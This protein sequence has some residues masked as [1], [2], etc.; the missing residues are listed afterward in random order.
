MVKLN[1]KGLKKKKKIILN[2]YLKRVKIYYKISI[3][4]FKFFD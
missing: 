2:K 1:I 4:I 3:K